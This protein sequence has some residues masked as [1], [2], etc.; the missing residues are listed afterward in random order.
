MSWILQQQVSTATT[1]PATSLAVTVTAP[2]QNNLL[3]LLVQAVDN[4]STVGSEAVTAVAQTN[5]TWTNATSGQVDFHNIQTTSLWYGVAGASPGTTV[6]ISCS[7]GDA[8][9]SNISA[10]FTEWFGGMAS[11]VLDVAASNVQGPSVTTTPST[12]SV[13]MARPSELVVAG[14][15]SGNS[16]VLTSTGWISLIETNSSG[17]AQ[18]AQCWGA[19]RFAGPASESETATWTSSTTV[20]V[21]SIAAFIAPASSGFPP[22]PGGHRRV[23]TMINRK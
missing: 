20:C 13:V 6:T 2:A 3:V 5:V 7:N 15:G 21:M 14:G 1:T 17:G 19:Y 22:G 23:W 8:T 10:N 18:T 12:C 9:T 4:V 11:N 16:F